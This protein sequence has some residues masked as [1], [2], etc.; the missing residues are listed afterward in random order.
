MSRFITNHPTK[1]LATRLADL[2]EASLELKFLVGFFYFSGWRELYEP[3]KK[4][5]ESNPDFKLKVLV[6]LSVDRPAGRLLEVARKAE[7]TGRE[8]S[9]ALLEE[10]AQALSDPS[11]DLPDFP[12]QARFFLRL[13]REGRLEIRKTREPN[14][15]KLYLFKVDAPQQR[16]LG[17][18]GKFI[19]GSSNLTH[20]G[21]RGQH[22]FNVEI[23]DYGFE[24]AEGYFD[25]LWRSAVPLR[26]EDFPRLEA[27]IER[28]SLAEQ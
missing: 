17:S 5:V 19:T 8:V 15:A 24:E 13:L 25:E 6:G 18:P 21:L 26:L 7:G 27:L 2:T 1:D 22:E 16:L 10:Y 14:H 9:R 12:E 11:L 28:G 20:A 4:A 3:L 23:G